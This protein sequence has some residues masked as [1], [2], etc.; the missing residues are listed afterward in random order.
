MRYQISVRIA[1]GALLAVALGCSETEPPTGPTPAGQHPAPVAPPPALPRG[2]GSGFP[3]A[4]GAMAIYNRSTPSAWVP[5]DSRYVLGKDGTFAL[6]YVPPDAKFLEYKGTYERSD[7]T[8]TFNFA[9]GA[10]QG[11]WV[12][13]GT[14]HGDSLT[15]VYD[16]GMSF[17]GFEDGIFVKDSDNPAAA[18]IYVANLDGGAIRRIIA[19]DSPAWS[20]DGR[21]IAFHRD[22]DV[23]VANGDGSDEKILAPGSS[24]TWSPDATRLAFTST[25]G[26][27]VMNADGSDVRT[28]IVHHFRTDTYAPWDMGV[29]KPSWSPDGERIAFEHLGDGDMQPAH[30]FVMNAD[31]SDPHTVTT[32]VNGAWYAESDPSWSPDGARIVFWSYGYGIASV[33]SKG[34]EPGTIYADFPAVAYGT[35]PVWSPDGSTLAFTMHAASTNAAD[36]WTVGVRGGDARRLLVGGRQPAWSPDRKTIAFVR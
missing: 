4:P 12:A 21:R 32:S 25:K 11:Y 23:Y 19:G 26:I 30:V 6:Q 17:D 22:G 2:D 31:G 35:K 20:P 5:G 18:H 9:A 14:I 10:S 24:P 3:P 34:G 29:D 28:L 27:S 1:L 15:V 8:L 16:A 36:I 7:S 13:T 33:D